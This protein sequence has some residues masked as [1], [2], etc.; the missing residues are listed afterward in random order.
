MKTILDRIIEN[1]QLEVEANKAAIGLSRLKQ[2]PL[3][4]RTCY[5]FGEFI[6]NKSGVIAEFKRKSPSKGIINPD[7]L[8]AEVTKG[9]ENAGA[10]A[11]SVLTDTSFFGG[12]NNDLLIARAQISIPILRKDF[13]IDTFQIIEAKAIGADVILLIAACLTV[14]QCKELAAFAKDLGL[15]VFLELHTEAEL[16]YINQNID[17][18]GINNRNLKTFEVDIQNSLRLSSLL[19]ADMV[20]VAESGIS[21]PE[22]IKTFKEGGFKGF[23]IGENFMKTDNPELACSNFIKAING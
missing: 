9:Y 4:N 19:P 20:K 18:V 16:E 23:L 10:S 11:V 3:F 7:A 1:K 21:N 12:T 2:S 15:N 22:I 5:N 14:K 8:V 13:I 17:V 6:L